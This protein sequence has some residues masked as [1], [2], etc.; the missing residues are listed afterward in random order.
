[1]IARLILASALLQLG[2]SAQLQ[3]LQF[4][5]TTATPVS[6]PQDVGTAAPGDTLDLRFQIKNLGAG[7][8]PVQKIDVTG[9]GFRLTSL[10]A[11][12]FNLA[13]QAIVDFHVAFTP[14]SAATYSAIITVNTTATTIR[15]TGAPPQPIQTA[16]LQLLLFN[17]TIATPVS[18]PQDV[19]TA[20]PGDTLD[21]RF[22]IK[23]LGVGAATLQTLVVL[24][25]A[26][27][28]VSQPALPYLLAPQAIVEFHVAF[29][30]TSFASYSAIVTVNTAATTIRATAVPAPPGASTQLQLLQL[31]GTTATPVSNLQD[32][33]T[34]AP[35]DTLD[36]RFQIKN[37]GTVAAT[38]QTIVV[39]GTAFRLSA[40]PPLPYILASQAIVEFHVAFTPTS[41]A[42]Y[43]AVVTLN[44]TTTTIRATAVAAALVT[45][46]I[47]PLSAG[48]TAD[49][50]QTESGTSVTKTFTLTNSNPSAALS[51]GVISIS[52]A[53]FAGP[54]GISAPLTLPPG[55][56]AS[57]QVVFAPLV[58][59]Q[60]TGT[61][62]IDQRT[63]PLIGL[64]TSA[65]LPKGTI[66]L[67]SQNPA[68]S[69]QL[70]VSIA[71]A[72]AS[73]VAGNGTLAMTFQPASGLPDD[74]AIQFLSGAKRFASVTITAGESFARIGTL[75]DFAFQTGTT[76][77]TIVFTL[78]LPNSTDPLSVPIAPTSVQFD[79]A[80]TS[81]V[82]RVNDLDV[83]IAGFDNTHSISQLGFTFY[84]ASGRAIQPGMIRYDATSDF[85]LYFT[86]NPGYGG[87]FTMRAT[88]PITGD[89]SQ[90]AAVDVQVSNSAGVAGT[91][92]LKF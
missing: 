69:Q 16:P 73:K 59:G 62:S 58:P 6:N 40:Q 48:T 89:A 38:V 37:L 57:F 27:R 86:A 84:D 76:A 49:F 28:V 87:M 72:A 82:R 63:F 13:S 70:K 90:I 68:S 32:V 19:G 12:P 50:G 29:S 1:M 54:S 91:Q 53:A 14:T 47:A 75:P 15:A 77:G 5:G 17:G 81:G 39:T 33:G 34:A 21:L 45:F 80:K 74:P 24:G 36:L 20:A 52:G 83:N 42:A 43:S 41:P 7:P 23:N 66:V 3:L 46:G 71:L 26:F 67:S 64:A 56:S 51:I 4:S 11:L 2:A 31:N 92:R 60:A 10:P 9:A 30:P 88:F 78:T 55:A 85:K 22:Q 35:G 25:T 18:N 79:L 61:L 65:P 44:T 8:A